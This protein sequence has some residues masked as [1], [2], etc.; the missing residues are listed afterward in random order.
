MASSVFRSRSE[1]F[2]R[3]FAFDAADGFL[4]VVGNGLGEIPVDAGELLELLVHGG[5]QVIF[6]AVEFAA[7]LLARMKIDEEFG[8]VEAAG[9]AA[10]VGAADLADDLRDLGEIRQHE[11]RLLGHVDAGGR[12][13][14]GRQR[15]AHP[16]RAFV[17]VRQKFGADDSADREEQHGRESASSPS[18]A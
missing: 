14:A 7:P 3:E 16:D 12:T 5:D 8:V 11:A 13:G 10:V 17:E 18:R 2:D 15:A 6:V 9:I 4:D 1:E